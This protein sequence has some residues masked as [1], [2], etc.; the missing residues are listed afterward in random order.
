MRLFGRRLDNVQVEV[1]THCQLN[2]LMCPKSVFREDWIHRHMD[3]DTFRRIPFELF[4]YAHLQGWGE[5]LLNPDIIEM[6]E[7]AKRE[8]CSVGITTNGIL[9][10]EFAEDLV[11]SGVDLVAVSIASP[12]NEV[13]KSIRGCDLSKLIEGILKLSKM[14][15]NNKPKITVTTIMLRSTIEDLPELVKLA[16]SCGADEVIANNLDYIPTKD[17]VGLE[18]FSE[19]VDPKI[20]E[21]LDSAKTTARDLGINLAIRPIKLEEALICA[22]NPLKTCFITVDGFV[23][24]CVYAHLPTKSEH[25]QRVFKN[26]IVYVKKLYFGNINEKSFDKIWNSEEYTRFREVFKRRLGVDMFTIFQ[27]PDLPEICKSCYKA[28][29]L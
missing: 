21:I 23:S 28:Y 10:D 12:N 4:K 24:P 18:V 27:F 7:I 29:S 19:K 1:S 25:V 5:P 2:C 16:K 9:L 11:R 17:L 20:V 22:E 13:H 6:I 26:R 3:L 15:R 14:R 8:G